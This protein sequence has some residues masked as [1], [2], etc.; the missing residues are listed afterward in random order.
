[1]VLTDR[2]PLAL[3][4]ALRSAKCSGVGGV[5]DG[6]RQQITGPVPQGGGNLHPQVYPRYF[7]YTL[8]LALRCA[9]GDTSETQE[10]PLSCASAPRMP[11]APQHPYAKADCV[12][13]I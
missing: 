10:C 11:V 1:M 7:V 6:M 5:S 3:E 9:R 13:D 4:C 2:E 8:L 12:Q